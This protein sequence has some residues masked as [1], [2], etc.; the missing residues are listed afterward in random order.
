MRVI[1]KEERET[2]I[3]RV[4]NTNGQGKGERIAN[5]LFIESTERERAACY[6]L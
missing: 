5:I 2:E 6:S 1:N 4:E 3:E